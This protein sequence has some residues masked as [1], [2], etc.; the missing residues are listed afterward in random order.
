MGP[1]PLAEESGEPPGSLK[2][3]AFFGLPV[4]E[5]QRSALDGYLAECARRAPQFRWTRDA[6]LHLTV[7]FLG[8]LEFAVAEQ[9]ADRLVDANLSA[10]VVRLGDVGAFKRGRLAR[11]L[12]IGLAEGVTESQELAA[13]LESECARAGLEAE[14]RPFSP[15][16]TLA[17]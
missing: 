11:V 9:I 6:N 3:R 17:R 12:W 7:R 4:P 13:A 2:V 14:T 1:D 16:L 10:F 15:H 5:A 8:R